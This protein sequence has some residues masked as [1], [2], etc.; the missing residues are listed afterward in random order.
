M[1]PGDVLQL[2]LSIGKDASWSQ[3]PYWCSISTFLSYEVR[4]K[5]AYGRI[6]V[7]LRLR[8][9]QM[10]AG[11]LIGYW[12][13]LS[14]SIL[15][16]SS[17]AV[18]LPTK[19]MSFQCSL[20]STSTLWNLCRCSAS[21]SVTCLNLMRFIEWLLEENQLCYNFWK[22]SVPACRP[23]LWSLNTMIHSSH[24]IYSVPY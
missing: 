19:P 16:S 4:V 18:Q 15:V 20:V 7:S 21:N 23:P 22:N 12:S 2:T 3:Y 1:L 10:S 13:L 9:L 17:A 6:S 5:L 24:K 11:T 8:M 14:V